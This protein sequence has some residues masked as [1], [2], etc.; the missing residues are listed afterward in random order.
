MA[1]P[2]SIS[3]WYLWSALV[4]L[5]GCG[6]GQADQDPKP[7]QAGQSPSSLETAARVASIQGAALV[8]DQEAVR[9]NVEAMNED[10]RKAIRLSDPARAVDR[11]QARAVA[12]EVPGVRSVV[13]LDRENLFVTVESAEAR[14]YRTIDRI[15]VMLEP[16]GDTL[17]VVVNLQNSAARDGD[18]LEILSRNCQLASGERALLSRE[19][20]IDVIDPEI[21]ALHRANQALSNQ[22][23]EDLARQE[24]SLRIL[25]RSTPSVYD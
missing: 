7:E 5:G 15:C 1:N 10:F 6:T 11:E 17:G 25:E 18:E 24:E 16:L 22:S 21:R 8:G 4:G 13:W 14:S 9:R 3:R 19:R 20:E 2:A 23:A 12:R